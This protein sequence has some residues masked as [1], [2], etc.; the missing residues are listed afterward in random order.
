MV[1]DHVS[2]RAA[3]VV[4]VASPG[5]TKGFRHRDLHVI[6][7]MAI[8]YRFEKGIGKTKKIKILNRFL[9]EKMVDAENRSLGENGMQRS[10][11]LSCRGQLA[12]KRLFDNDSSIFRMG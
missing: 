2:N 7:K 4:N 11:Q 9:A 10:I 3:F 1:L 8:P 6:D 5:Y 12:T